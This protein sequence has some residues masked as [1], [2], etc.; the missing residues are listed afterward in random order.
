[1]L[2]HLLG[3]V[4]KQAAAAK[5]GSH[6]QFGGG[7]GHRIAGVFMVLAA[8]MVA[9]HL[10]ASENETLMRWTPVRSGTPDT[11]DAKPLP[12]RPP[13]VLRMAYQSS[14][15]PGQPQPPA[16]ESHPHTLPAPEMIPTP[17]G[18]PADIAYEVYDSPDDFGAPRFAAPRFAAPQFDSACDALPSRI[19]RRSSCSDWFR[20]GILNGRAGGFW[21]RAEYL[22]WDRTGMDLPP[23]VTTSPSGTLRDDAGVFGGDSSVLLAG[24]DFLAE[25]E[26]GGR[27]SIGFWWDHRR[28]VA[29][30]FT[31]MTLGDLDQTW[32]ATSEQFPILAR[33]FFNVDVGTEDARLLGFPGEVSGDIRINGS[34]SFQVFDIAI[35]RSFSRSARD[36]F[37]LSLG[38]RNAELNE[39]FQIS[40]QSTSLTGA[41]QGTTVAATDQFRTENQFHGVQFGLLTEYR[42]WYG[43]RLNVEGSVAFGQTDR[44]TTI[45]GQTVTRTASGQTS[46]TSGGLLTQS[47]NSGTFDTDSFGVVH[48]LTLRARRHFHDGLSGMIGYGIYGWS[49]VGRAGEQIDRFVNPTQIPP[50]TLTGPSR[51]AFTDLTNDFIAHG[52]TFGVE[53]AW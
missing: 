12:K 28:D 38:Y 46:T 35:R 15:A 4:A 32:S 51:P 18:A 53:L 45:A 25:Q 7:N 2:R 9:G 37:F 43:W 24:N 52:V 11:R 31:Y 34:S 30:A 41:V 23:L 8:G 48:D 17:P 42:M 36:P 44:T 27:Y 19:R 5:L 39:S 6:P 16:T 49:N 33:P 3:R 14:D 13:A 47:S 40:D 10:R 50:G 21:A 1:M 20:P 26:S 29:L 22:Y